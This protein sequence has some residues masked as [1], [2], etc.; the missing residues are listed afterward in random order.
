MTGAAMQSSRKARVEDK[1]LYNHAFKRATITYA[2]EKQKKGGLSAKGVTELIKN[3]F[4]VEIC[5]RSIQKY[6]KNGCIGVSPQR[7]GPKGEI[8]E[9]HFKNLCLAFES[10]IVINQNNGDARIRTYKKLAKLLQKEVYGDSACHVGQ[11]AHHLLQRVLND[12]AINL[13]AGKTKNAEDRRVRWTNYKNISMWFDNWEHDLVELGFTR[14][15]AITKKVTILPEQLRNMG[16]LD[17]TNLSLDGSTTTRGGRPAMVLYDPRFPQ[18]GR[19]TSKSSLSVTMIAGSN[20]AGEAF[21]PHLQFPSK[22][23]SKE[24]MRLDYDILDHIPQVRGRFGCEEEHLWPVTFGVNEKGGMDDNE[25]ANYIMNSIVPLYPHAKDKRG[26]RVLLKVDSGPGRTNM[27]L[28]AKLKMLG[29]I[30][31]PCV[32]NTTH[33][34]QETDQNYGP[35]KTQFS[36]N[37]ELIVAARLE[38]DVSLSLGPKFV[39]LPLFGGIDPD[40]GCHIEVGAFE[41]GF[42]PKRCLGAWSRIGA[43]T[44]NGEITRNCL[45]DKQVLRSLGDDD[46]TDK[47][48]WAIQAANNIATLALER[49]GYDASLLK[50]TFKE[51]EEADQLITVPNTIARQQALANARGHGGRFMV[52]GGMHSTS[53]DLF[54]AMEMSA[55]QKDKDETEKNKKLRLQLQAVEEKAIAIM[56]QGKSI[57]SLTVAELDVLLSWHQAT[58]TKGAKKADKLEQWKQI[59]ESG[60]RP[61]DYD[62]WTAE[63]E[64]RLVGLEVQGD[65]IDISSTRYG[66]EIALKKRELEAAANSMTREERNTW[67]Q[68]L[69]E[70]DRED[71]I[72]AMVSLE[73]ETAAAVTASTDGEVGAV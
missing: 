29:F 39:G 41:E 48:Y 67:Q 62:R 2:R 8:D 6:V 57:N 12:T 1:K 42:K 24:Q 64:E 11:Q 26:H 28:L 60:K 20:A 65:T 55:C 35:F 3:E 70:L 51:K 45:S 13:N 18:V 16:N 47:L 66:R 7:R 53:D 25:F 14:V 54:I 73:A 21:P 44:R 9:L 34:T 72:E 19:A 38:A 10:F 58:K 56:A 27:D 32:P 33:V 71:A 46:N 40:T 5:T 52:T 69:D 31:Y 23:K 61:P 49:A 37:L 43:A 22:A 63:D 4:K 68:R 36:V 15:D 30:L 59:L 50:A 17:E